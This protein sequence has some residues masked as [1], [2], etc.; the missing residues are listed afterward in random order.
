MMMMIIIENI[1]IA[2][3][4]IIDPTIRYIYMGIRYTTTSYG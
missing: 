2:I 4:Y 1:I 3:Y